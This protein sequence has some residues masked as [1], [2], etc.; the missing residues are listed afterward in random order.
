MRGGLR[1]W[2]AAGSQGL[3]GLPWVGVAGV[4]GAGGKRAAVG[5]DLG[6]PVCVPWRIARKPGVRMKGQ[7]GGRG[8]GSRQAGAWDVGGGLVRGTVGAA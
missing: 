7:G 4:A 5:Q 8:A 2:R 3:P 6:K 1:P